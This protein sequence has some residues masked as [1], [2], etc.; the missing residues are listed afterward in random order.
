MRTQSPARKRA[1]NSRG[2]PP[3]RTNVGTDTSTPCRQEATH[4]DHSLM[5]PRLS[6]IRG[7]IEGIERM[8]QEGRYCVEIL[9]QFRA[10][11]AAL[12]TVEVTVFNTHLGHCVQ[13]AMKS[14]NEKLIETKI[15]ELTDLL[16]RRSII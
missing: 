5:L 10:A 16:E 6:K 12:R 4:P 14:K 3:S 11:M 9:I 2:K 13:S 15:Q 1:S 7:Q 8:I